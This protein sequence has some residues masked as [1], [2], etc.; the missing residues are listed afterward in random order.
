MS[1]NIKPHD[2]VPEDDLP[3]WPKQW[4]MTKLLWVEI[5]ILLGMF[6]A[7][8]TISFQERQFDRI[9]D[10]TSQVSSAVTRLER[11]TKDD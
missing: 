2:W 11:L 1:T 9:A 7:G 4:Y 3:F 10:V 8:R 6:I 5:L